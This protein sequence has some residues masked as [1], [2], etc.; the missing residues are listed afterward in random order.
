M[1][2]SRAVSLNFPKDSPTRRTIIT[3]L[4][5]AWYETRAR[6]LAAAILLALLGVSTVF[7]AEPTIR[8][9]E[10]F[11]RGESMPY[12]LYVWLSLSKGYLMFF[13]VICAV[14]LG[15]GGL[16]REHS[17]GT[18]GFTLSLPVSRRALVVTRALVGAAEAFA[19]AL[20]PGILVAL[21]SPAIG[22]SYPLSQAL[23]FGIL[24][25][26]GGMIFYSL[27]FFLSHLF[28]GEFA[29]PGVGLAIV[30]GVYVITRLPQL[31]DLDVFDLMT[32]SH[33]MI[34]ATYLLGD[35]FPI[36]PLIC[37]LTAAGGLVALSSAI[38]SRRDF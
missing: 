26:G 14:I 13:W 4:K 6:F 2:I 27:G 25:A 1:T 30:A 12:T 9:W 38:A 37:S 28:R 11:H 32:G 3:L 18:V 8:A 17:T 35:T 16:V 19:L 22:Y 10:S 5:K 31:D 15:L 36:L 23:L 21:L 29:A 33:Y 20:I 24:M 34:H 7:R